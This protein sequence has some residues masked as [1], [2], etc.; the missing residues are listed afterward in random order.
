MKIDDLLV[1][2]RRLIGEYEQL[3]TDVAS[4]N[5]QHPDDEIA[6]ATSHEK[7]LAELRSVEAQLAART[8]G[9]IDDD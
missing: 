9:D 4:W 5:D 7:E 1:T 8:Q 3:G 2:A 6:L